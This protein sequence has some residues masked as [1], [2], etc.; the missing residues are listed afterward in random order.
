[1]F[2]FTI[3]GFPILGQ[4][5]DVEGLWIAEA[6]W[7]MHSGGV[8]KVMAEWMANGVPSLDLRECD[9]NRF[10]SYAFNVPYIKARAAQQYREVYDIIHPMQPIKYPR[11]LRLTP[12]HPR[13]DALGA[14]FFE[15]VGWERPQWFRSNEK[16]VSG[17]LWPLRTGWEARFW[18]PAQGYEHFATRSGV[19]VYDMTPFTKLDVSGP[20]ALKYL[21]YLSANDI[22]QAAGK[23]VYTAML[24]SK[25]GIM[26]DLTITRLA[27]DRFLVITGGAMGM[28]DIAWMKQYL[29]RDGSVSMAD[30]SSGYCCLGLWGPRAQELLERLSSERFSLSSFKQFTA[31]RFFIGNV[32]V[33]ALRVSYVGE[34]GW[35]IYA[36]TGYGLTL[37]D[38]LWD[39]GR[40]FGLVPAGGAAFDSLRL[41]KGYRLWGSDI[42]SE[43]NPFEAG[44]GFAV[45]LNKGEFLGREALLQIKEN[46]VQRKLSRMYFNEPGRIVMGK[47]PILSGERTV[48]YVTSSNYGYTIGKGIAYGYLPI[49]LAKAGT[50]VEIY[51]FGKKHGASVFA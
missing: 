21:Q 22:D 25:G 15:N 33:L 44:L 30:V 23:V 28:H 6:I 9:V 7:I 11:N 4:W 19:A 2:S 45:K 46:G 20:G 27:E 37:W 51:Y 47:E 48:G 18:S 10:H 16:Y 50:S 35:E 24:N 40:E 43:Y 13:L 42:H 38:T 31:E 34:D 49:D 5:R 32:P 17:Q 39:A 36:E 12:F 41:E 29:P 14:E 3:D 8:G 1:M 26:C